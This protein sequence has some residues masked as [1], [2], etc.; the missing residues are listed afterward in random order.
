MPLEEYRRKRDFAKTRNPR[1]PQRPAR[2]APSVAA[3]S[4]SSVTARPASTTTSASRSPGVQA[5]VVQENL[6]HAKVST[7]LDLYAHV[8]PSTRREAADTLAALLG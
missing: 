4:S 2:E 5:K 8:M 6:G 7:T 1:P 3:V